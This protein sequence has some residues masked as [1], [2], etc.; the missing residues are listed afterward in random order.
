MSTI[1]YSMVILFLTKNLKLIAIAV[2]ILVVAFLLIVNRLVFNSIQPQTNK[3]STTFS[4]EIV[5]YKLEWQ[6]ENLFREFLD[7]TNFSSVEH[8]DKDRQFLGKINSIHITLTSAELP[9]YQ[10]STNSKLIFASDYRIEGEKL[11]I[12]LYVNNQELSNPTENTNY[13]INLKI[14]QTLLMSL[15]SLPS[16]QTTVS[17]EKQY[18]GK[19][20]TDRFVINQQANK[21]PFRLLKE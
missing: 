17:S 20:Y 6:N 10:L 21:L 5:G 7:S 1:L 15:K 16:A 13:G 14:F 9:L 18:L 19:I 12:L 4:S 8:T 3:I 11:Q 2:A